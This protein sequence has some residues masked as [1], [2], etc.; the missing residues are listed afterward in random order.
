MEYVAIVTREGR[1]WLAEFPDCPGCQTFASSRRA[2]VK[3]AQEVL[4]LW[5]DASLDSRDPPSLPSKHVAGARRADVVEL[6]PVV[7]P[8]HLATAVQ[9]RALRKAKGLTQAQLAAR[10]HVTQQAIAKLE[11]PGEKMLGTVEKVARALG[12]RLSIELHGS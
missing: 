3:A 12:S 9:I 4:E 1:H 7:V 6:L 10:A 2:L 5:L 8:A 11:R